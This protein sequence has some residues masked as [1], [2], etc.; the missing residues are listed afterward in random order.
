MLS[1]FPASGTHLRWCFDHLIAC[2][3][4]CTCQPSAC[5]VYRSNL[6]CWRISR[7][8]KDRDVAEMEKRSRVEAK[9]MI[10]SN[11][12][13][14]RSRIRNFTYLNSTSHSTAHLSILS[15]SVLDRK[16][17]PKREARDC[18]D[19]YYA[20]MSKSCFV[21]WRD[22]LRRDESEEINVWYISISNPKKCEFVWEVSC[23]KAC[24]S[25]SGSYI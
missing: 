24:F 14:T 25:E 4:L 10:E 22:H 5:K 3:H 19:R 9:V 8:R 15:L 23:V 21:H 20:K 16:V 18:V 13:V 2:C 12:W 17:G 7:I 11:Q 1:S 6:S